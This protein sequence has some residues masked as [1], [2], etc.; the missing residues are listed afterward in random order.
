MDNR[1][2]LLEQAL[3]LFAQRGYD[4]IG[5]QEIVEQVGVTKPTLYHYFGSKRGVLE[6]LINER[7]QPLIDQLANATIHANDVPASLAAIFQVYFDFAQAEPLLYRMQLAMWFSLPDNEAFQIVAVAAE[8]QQALLE[9]F[10]VRASSFHG[11]M[12]G[13]QRVYAATLLGTINTY[14][15][16]WLSGAIQATPH[17]IHQA[18]QQFSHGIYS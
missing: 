1:A 12:R 10:F 18:V 9:S 3:Q 14:I 5:V 2:K 15:G 17:I 8:Q 16:L 11:N 13:R 4:A 7:L 6:A